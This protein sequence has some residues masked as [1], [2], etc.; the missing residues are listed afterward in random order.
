V[1]PGRLNGVLAA[2]SQ[3]ASRLNFC[4]GAFADGRFAVTLAMTN[5]GNDPDDRADAVDRADP[6]DPLVASEYLAFATDP[7]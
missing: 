6:D 5:Q 7:R 3:L 2:L 1:Y 4:F